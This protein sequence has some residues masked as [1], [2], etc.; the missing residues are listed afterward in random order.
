M[1]TATTHPIPDSTG[2]SRRGFMGLVGAGA[3]VLGWNSLGSRMAFATPENPSTGDVIVVV[4]MRGG[5]DGLSVVAPYQM[6]TY[7]ALRPNIRIKPASEFTDPTGR[8]GLPLE[9][10]G[11]VAP[12]PL[13]GT[14]AMHPSMSALHAGAW[15]DGKLAVIHAAGMPVSESSTRSHF[16]AAEYWE[17]GSRS[18]AVTTGFLNRYLG[19]L[20][21][22]DR[23]SAVGRGSTLQSSLQ[24]PSTA[25]S[26]GSI[27]GF[28]VRGFPDNTR[29]RNA[30]IGLYRHGADLV[31]ETGADTLDVVNLLASIP[32]D[33]G[34][35]NGAAY[36]TDSLSQNLKEVA[37]LIRSNVGLRAVAV[38]FGG[39]DTHS[40]MGLAEDPNSYM[41]RQT[42]TV[43][44]ALQAFHQDLGSAM[45]EVTLV[46]LSE[47]GRTIDENGSQGT[48]HGRGTLMLAMGGKIRG[49]VHGSFPS[50]ITNGPEGDLSVLNDYRRVLSEILQVRC[51]ATNIS[52]IFPT[53]TQQAPLGVAV[54]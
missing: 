34:P 51:G 7:Q 31:A 43:S 14:F 23:L 26:M 11:N 10:G 40:N 6:P 39:W 30:L 33:P 47:F 24:G 17:R 46:T 19:G 36:G 9:A 37:R 44:Q 8:A 48:D 1:S 20:D 3:S 22:L 4:F 12:F 42:A 29:A 5:W 35:Q 13:S 49:G 52:S 16:E 15:S 54:A 18:L 41:R 27:S 25:M 21:G 2:V 53:Y 28:G 38:D 50:E 45:D 32:P